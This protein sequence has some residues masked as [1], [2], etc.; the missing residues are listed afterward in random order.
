[1]ETLSNAT[2][3]GRGQCL[4][5]SE[6]GPV[7]IDLHFWLSQLTVL[8]QCATNGFLCYAHSLYEDVRLLG[9]RIIDCRIIG[10]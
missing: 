2:T 5:S 6:S 3:L 10:A 7:C 8:I 1:M 4:T 9:C